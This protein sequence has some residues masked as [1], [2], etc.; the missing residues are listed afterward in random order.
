M[1]VILTPSINISVNNAKLLF[2]NLDDGTGTIEFTIEE[3]PVRLVVCY[4]SYVFDTAFKIGDRV[5]LKETW[6]GF[7]ANS[8]GILR[9]IIIDSTRDRGLVFF[10]KA[11]PD[12]S[13][14]SDN[15]T[16]VV[17]TNISITVE[18]SLDI[19]EII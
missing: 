17:S 18:T 16:N 14:I 11:Y 19:L 12:Q 2:E 9:E 3:Q 1:N 4:S 8:E 5:K 13:F 15:E 10:D 6:A 7:E